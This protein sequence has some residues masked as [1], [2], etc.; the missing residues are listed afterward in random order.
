MLKNAT[1]SFAFIASMF[2]ANGVALAEDSPTLEQV[3]QAAH[4][5]RLDDAQRMMDTV[6]KDHPGSAKAHYVEAELLA[7][8][9]QMV[10]ADGELHTAERLEPG[11]PF[12][13]PQSVQDLKNRIA[14]IH[15]AG[16][17]PD[18]SGNSFPWGMLFLG[19][20]VI[21]V[22]S[23]II[24]AIRARA[25]ARTQGALT[26]SMPMQPGGTGATPM[27]SGIGSGIVGGLATGA[28]VGA[29]IVAGE[30]LAH[31]LLDGGHDATN[32]AP[33]ADAG[34]GSSGD[35]GGSDFGIA[36]NSSWNDD[37]GV[38][39]VGSDVGGGDWS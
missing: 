16:A 24:S 10:K 2:L 11:L 14:G 17:S 22:I 19:I 27:G 12:A 36:D 15:H 8:Q 34:D 13:N 28:A 30:M 7:K 31:R 4:A 38:A 20:G 37:S 25:M 6:L 35:M 23:L 5:G 32:V 26:G 21:A 33:M 9:N 39:D 18:G 1:F 29:G 3:Y